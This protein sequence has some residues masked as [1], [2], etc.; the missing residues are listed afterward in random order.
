MIG[1]WIAS[2]ILFVRLRDVSTL[3]PATHHRGSPREGFGALKPLML[4]PLALMGITGPATRAA[5]MVL[6]QENCPDNRAM[7]NGMFLAISFVLESG[8]SVVMGA[9]GD[10]FGLERAFLVS[11]VILLLG[12]PVVRLLPGRAPSRP[13]P[14]G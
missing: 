7:A 1:G 11:A 5:L 2:A 3:S 12:S 6:V 9:L 8:A 10:A 4:P 13:E 14:S